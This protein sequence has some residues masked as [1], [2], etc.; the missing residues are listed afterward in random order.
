MK[1]NLWPRV[2]R[3]CHLLSK[4]LKFR[5]LGITLEISSRRGILYAALKNRLSNSRYQEGSMRI[6]KTAIVF[7]AFLVV[8]VY[9]L[10]RNQHFTRAQTGQDSS[11][12]C[13]GEPDTTAPREIDFPYYSLRDGFNSTLLLVSD[14]PKPMDLTVAVRSMTGQTV[15]APM[16]IQPQEKLA[17]DLS[18]LLTKLSADVNGA[19]AEGSI[20]VYF[21]GTIMPLTGQ[22]T[23]SNPAL[24]LI[25]ESQ[26]VENDPGH[27]DLPA[28]LNG[29]WWNLG[30]GRDARIMVSNT[31]GDSVI[32]DVFL[33]FQGSRH[34]SSPL[35]FMGH[36]TKVL[37]IT[38][39]LGDLKASPAEAPEGGITIIPRGLKPTLIANGKILDPA[40]GFSTSLNFPLPQL[41]ISNALHAS[42][43][44]VGTPTKDSPFARM[45]TFIP[46]V[47]VRNLLGSQQNVS[48]T[49][50]FP[51]QD[52]TEQTALAPLSVGAYS[53]QD[54]SFASVLGRLPLPL[55]YASIRIQYSGP[56]GSVIAEVSSV[57]QRHDLVIDSRLANE[58][59][60]TA[61]GGAHP[62]HLDNETESILF[63]TNM[64]DQSARIGFH[65]Q[66]NG[67]HYF[68]TNLKLNP[69]ETRA[70]DFRELRDA[71]VPDFRKNTIPTEATDGSVSWIRIDNVPV[72]G[73]L[74]VI[75]RHKGMASNYD[76]GTGCVCPASFV[77]VPVT[78]ASFDVL[79]GQTM[80][81][82][83]KMEFRDCNGA[84]T[85]IT[86]SSATWSSTNTA[87]ATV[88]GSTASGTVHAIAAG[89][90]TIDASLT[91]TTYTQS[92]AHY[93]TSKTVTIKGPSACNVRIPYMLNALPTTTETV[94]SG[95]SCMLD[96]KYQVLDVNGA[97]IYVSG[98]NVAES[99]GFAPG[100]PC[101]G[102]WA[103]AGKWTTDGTG[104]MTTP[105]Y[106]YWCCTNGTCTMKFTQTFTVN[107]YP[108][109]VIKYNGFAGTHNIVTIQCSSSNVATCPAIVPTP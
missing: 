95:K 6:V 65:A 93:C 78:P 48:I 107:G 13:C 44:P 58:G 56:P 61:G 27:S 63:L 36:E 53:T 70:I 106:W 69:H 96:I 35:M 25:H 47:I 90:A 85:F 38:K 18:T 2:L 42:G 62:W 76:C 89:T 41:Q 21:S 28:V 46:H 52:G 45:G 98:M 72:M 10:H 67:V 26:L 77:A 29:L 60:G 30:G 68:L 79:P 83:C 24:G 33:D 82:T 91:G 22:L 64:G 34:A 50:E 99:S 7:A 37:S 94:C 88:S 97:A 20:S 51:G 109:Y 43:V 66:A 59:D 12:P 55:P 87:V 5:F 39:L 11:T 104:T 17:V 92:G 74:V 102:S 19:F 80:D 23:M 73:R 8:G 16:S 84:Q 71:Q 40:T 49:V 81:C 14:S 108:I 4:D 75:E 100:S 105:D 32:A 3:Y 31:G 103:D 1:V 101:T 86:P 57:E 15:F 54:F 9:V